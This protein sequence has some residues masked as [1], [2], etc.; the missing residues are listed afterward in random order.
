M[1]FLF[2]KKKTP[3]SLSSQ[4]DTDDAPSTTSTQQPQPL[5]DQT[6]RNM[7]LARESL[8]RGDKVFTDLRNIENE[9]QRLMKKLGVNDAQSVISQSRLDAAKAVS[10][11]DV[12]KLAPP[13]VSGFPRR[14]IWEGSDFDDLLAQ[15]P[16]GIAPPPG[17]VISPPRS[18]DYSVPVGNRTFLQEFEA[19][20]AARNTGGRSRRRRGN[21]A[22]RSKK[23]KKS[24]RS[25]KASRR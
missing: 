9:K 17:A 15:A 11:Y 20:N 24:K 19:A 23:A 8:E 13:P 12:P 14:N 2:G 6:K 21:K 22:K 3:T 4:V 10:S 1:S 18:I 16:S 5:S 7:V 25:R